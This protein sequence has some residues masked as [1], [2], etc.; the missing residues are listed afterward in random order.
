MCF[1][2]NDKKYNF[3]LNENLLC[4][5]YGMVACV[6]CNYADQTVN[7]FS[8]GWSSHTS[9]WN[10]PYIRGDSDQM[11]LARHYSVFH[12]IINK[13][14]IYEAL[15]ITFVKHPFFTL[16]TCKDKWYDKR[17]VR[18]KIFKA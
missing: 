3:P 8:T 10:K 4:A 13:P 16:D 6:I 14:S 15:A 7:T 12:G 2:S 5:N 11:V 17:N 1:T 9:N 18:I